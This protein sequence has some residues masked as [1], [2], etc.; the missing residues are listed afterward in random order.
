M[1][2]IDVEQSF[3]W[4]GIGFSKETLQNGEA[5][6]IP[7]A[8]GFS[9]SANGGEDWEFR[10]P[11]LDQPDDTVEVYGVST[12]SAL[13]II[14]PEQSPPYDI[15]Y[16]PVNG[17]VW[18][19]N[20]AS[21]IRRSED[22]GRTWFRV[23]LPPDTLDFIHPDSSYD[24]PFAPERNPNDEA[25]NFLGFSVLVDETGTVWAGTAGGLNRSTDARTQG[26]NASWRRF[27]YDGST[28]GLV[29]NWIISI[30]EQILAGPNAIW[31]ACW[32]SIAEGEDF[33]ITVTRDGGATFEQVLIGEKIYDFAFDADRGR[34]YA[35][36]DNG[37]FITEDGGRTWRTIRHFMD[38][39]QPD[40]PVR[41]NVQIF[42]V[43]V[44]RGALWVG[45]GDGLLRSDDGGESWTLFR[46]E[47]PLRPDAP[48]ESVPVVDTYAYPNPYSPSN[49][50]IIRIRY[51]LE[52]EQQV[53]VRI[54]DFS[55]RLVRTIV[56]G[57]QS[58]CA[59][60][61]VWD[62]V[63]ERGAVVPNGVYFYTVDADA[64]VSGKIMVVD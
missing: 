19:A 64:S 54:F 40:R 63:D 32:P 17:W 1:F 24:F 7:T 27:H 55:S 47:T 10:L 42:A 2:S 59:R 50:G 11:P 21:G 15:D 16:D 51:D 48:S 61:A 30:E 62:G 6:S 53:T 37:L 35:A 33:G 3:A 29:G 49:D 52:S 46:A 12:L 39:A 20:W 9:F 43:A 56:D 41:P 26:S 5:E 23:V 22:N 8:L 57:A 58:G 14:V 4:I 36:G 25:N 38:A 18:S 45:S 44:V 60:E 28:R 34:A 31:A 13:P